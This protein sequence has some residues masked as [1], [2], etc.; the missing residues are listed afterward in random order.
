WSSVN[1][2]QPAFFFLV[3]QFVLLADS[4]KVFVRNGRQ[5]SLNGPKE[6]RGKGL[7]TFYVLACSFEPMLLVVAAMQS[8]T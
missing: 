1:H 5:C 8:P 6:P 3:S 4:A 7:S 2:T